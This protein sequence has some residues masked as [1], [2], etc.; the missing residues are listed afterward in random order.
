MGMSKEWSSVRQVRND[1]IAAYFDICVSEGDPALIVAALGDIARAHG[2]AKVARDIGLSKEYLS[3]ILSGNGNPKFATIV[4]VIKAVGLSLHAGNTHSQDEAAHIGNINEAINKSGRLAMLSQR[5]AKCYLQIGQSIDATRSKRAF[6]LSLV[7]F[8]RHL[9][10]LGAF[11]PIKDNEAMLVNLEMAWIDYKD[12][13]LGKAPNKKD[14]KT[15]LTMSEDLFAMAEDLTG[16]LLGRAATDPGKYVHIAGRQRA[17]SQRMAK[18]YEAMRWGVAPADAVAEL[19]A[20]RKA[21]GDSLTMLVLYPN[22]TQQ[23]R[24]ELELAEQQWD[25]FVDAL[26]DGLGPTATTRLD[27]DVASASENML[28]KL[29]IVTDLY[30]KLQ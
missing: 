10:E 24:A 14:A 7:L 15:M 2:I 26:F 3:S 28:E 17:L 1:D 22:N 30:A 5:L 20:G 4:K 29:E 27:T 25:F 16:Q 11:A 18:F 19:S 8:D 13:L 9:V 6:N 12:A 21:F 23:I